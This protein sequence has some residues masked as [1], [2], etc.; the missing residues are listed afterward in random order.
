MAPL[1][2][3]RG[4]DARTRPSAHLAFMEVIAIG[5]ERANV[6]MVQQASCDAHLLF[7]ARRAEPGALRNI[8]D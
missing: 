6:D 4:A 3:S 5:A 2:R 7:A 8:T 1:A